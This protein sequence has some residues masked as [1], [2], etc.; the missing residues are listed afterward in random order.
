MATPSLKQ[1][2][3]DSFQVALWKQLA[4]LTLATF[5]F[6]VALAWNGFI[7]KLLGK[8]SRG[9]FYLFAYAVVITLVGVFLVAFIFRAAHKK[10][11]AEKQSIIEEDNGEEQPELDLVL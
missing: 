1:R 5:S 10:E 7:D 3:G 8:Q 4:T 6:I 2:D 11:Q 9:V